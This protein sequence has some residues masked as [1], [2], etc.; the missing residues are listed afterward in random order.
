MKKIPSNRTKRVLSPNTPYCY[1]EI[2]I[3]VARGYFDGKRIY[4]EEK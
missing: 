4:Y 1:D 3:T 2:K